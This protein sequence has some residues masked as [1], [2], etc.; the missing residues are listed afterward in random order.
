MSATPRPHPP[1]P[2][3][4][5]S[6]V[7]FD[8]APF[9]A[10]LA[11]P[12]LTLRR[13]PALR[14]AAEALDRTPRM[15]AE[16]DTLTAEAARRASA[17]RWELE[18][19]DTLVTHALAWEAVEGVA[20][21]LTGHA[22]ALSYDRVPLEQALAFY[23]RLLIVRGLETGALWPLPT[24]A[25]WATASGPPARAALTS[26]LLRPGGRRWGRAM[27]RRGDPAGRFAQALEN[28]DELPPDVAAAL[29][30]ADA[31]DA[32]ERFGMRGMLRGP[33]GELSLD[34]LVSAF[35]MIPEAVTPE[36]LPEAL[37]LA[38]SELL[39]VAEAPLPTYDL[40]PD[41]D[42]VTLLRGVLHVDDALEHRLARGRDHHREAVAVPDRD[43]RRR[44]NYMGRTRRT[45]GLRFESLD[46]AG[47]GGRLPR[48]ARATI[49]QAL[50][51][52]EL[53]VMLDRFW[54]TRTPAQLRDLDL[55]GEDYDLTDRR[56]L[57][58]RAGVRSATITERRQRAERDLRAF[59]NGE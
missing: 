30:G 59:L 10:D 28:G 20:C 35:R 39:S 58:R 21:L 46:G 11:L 5:E 8:L 25:A 18:P 1:Q 43:N 6:R 17:V 7:G 45:R 51:E 53:A 15:L 13:V 56:T 52:R 38:A 14:A 54:A 47:G 31:L 26:R 9:L 23:R 55:A 37:D 36:E 32:L 49:R 27:W 34:E 44:S 3:R 12:D 48:H 41:V 29:D 19:S 22:H 2:P 33:M 50:T 24:A 16:L 42:V 40:R 57:A 4:L